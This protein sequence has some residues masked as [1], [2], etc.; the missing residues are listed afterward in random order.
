MEQNRN[1]RGTVTSIALAGDRAAVPAQHRI[2]S[3]VEAGEM[4]EGLA[5]SP[6]GR[7]VA[8]ANL[9]ESFEPLADSKQQFFAS[10][11]L[12]QFNSANGLLTRVGDFPFDG[13]LPE[14]IVFDNSSRFL[15]A[16]SFARYEDPSAGGALHFWRI[17]E[18]NPQ[19]G[20]IELVE[21]DQSVPLP[22][23]PQSIAIV[24]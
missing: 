3:V 11:S 13:A 4:P 21:L 9:E 8:T 20:R 15:A 12:L 22:R 16:A 1:H 6:D 18:H 10:L 14:P 17:A 7:W 24:R 2:V 5:V 19:P 23:G